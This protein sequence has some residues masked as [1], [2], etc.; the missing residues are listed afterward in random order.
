MDGQEELLHALRITRADVEA[1]RAGRLGAAQRRRRQRNVAIGG[2]VGLVLGAG[3]LILSLKEVRTSGVEPQSWIVP[4]VTGLAVLALTANAV[5][6]TLR[7]LDRPVECITGTLTLRL[8]RIGRGGSSPRLQVG[9]RTFVLPRPPHVAGG[10]IPA[11]RAML[12]D[13]PYRV[14]VQG[15]RLLAIE[16]DAGTI[17]DRAAEG[18]PG[19]VAVAGVGARPRPRITWFAKACIVFVLLG[20]LGM[21]IAG[22]YLMV[23]QFTGTPAQATVTDCVQDPDSVNSSVTYDCT[24]T[25]V[26][27]GS[28][29]GG[30]GHVVVGTVDGVDNTDVGKTLDVRLSGSEAYAQSLVLPILLI[31]LGFPAAGLIVLLINVQRRG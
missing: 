12:T 9:G 23:L 6:A 31:A 29:V 1:N 19:S 2:L 26:V 17:L 30:N 28:L 5:W 22:V 15:V 10:V 4:A 3:I 7:G 16:P 8:I 21:G 18:A 24:G 20:V 25:W 27:G 13:G 14:Y 11:Y